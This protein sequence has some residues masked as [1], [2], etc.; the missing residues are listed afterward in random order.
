[1]PARKRTPTTKKLGNIT[2]AKFEVVQ[3][4][5][6]RPKRFQ[7]ASL[8]LDAAQ[9]L[10]TYSNPTYSDIELEYFEDAW[11]KSPA[12]TAVDKKM[13]F[14]VGKGV[15]RVFELLDEKNFD[16]EAKQKE[17]EKYDIYLDELIQLDQKLGFKQKLYDAAVMAK[18]FGRCVMTWEQEGSLISRPRSIKIVHPTDTGHL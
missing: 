18:V 13:E 14:V 7:S 12:G 10:K 5:V 1:M 8:R 17:L 6:G 16:D 2:K 3:R 9:E 15:K 4:G 11:R